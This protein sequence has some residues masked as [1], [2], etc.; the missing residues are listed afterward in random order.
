[1]LDLITKKRDGGALSAD[2]IRF[3]VGA[4][5][6]GSVPD[7]Q[8]SAWLMAVLLRGMTRAE[9]VALTSAMAASG[10]QL[11]LRGVKAPKADKHS[12]GGVGDGISL[13]LAPLVAAAGV[14]VPMMS[15]RGL[16]HTGGTL[17]KL[18]AIK[19]LRVRLGVD[20]VRRQMR[21][22]GVC[23]FGQSADFCPADRK[24]YALR[25]A[26]G[27]VQSRELIVGSILSKKL[28]E[29]LDA[30][31]LDIKCGS[32]AIFQEPA[33]AEELAK[34]LIRTAKGLGLPTVGLLTAMEQPLG[35]AIGNALEVRQAVEVLQGDFTSADYVEVLFGLG[36][37]MLALT[38]TARSAAAGEK[39]LKTL[40]REGKALEKFKQMIKAQGGDPRVADDP[41]R[42]LPKSKKSA[43]FAAGSAGYITRFD[44]LLAGRAGVALGAGRDRM[45]DRLDYGAGML[46]RRKVGDAVR[47]GE[48][49]ARLYSSSD[50]LLRGGLAML[51]RAVAIAP[52]RPRM[53]PV[54]RKIWR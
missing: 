50:R 44:A 42:F 14:A 49:I 11:T 35:R 45:E 18:E 32:G 41:E 24:L 25:D 1:M 47:K 51:E 7:Y 38:G 9:T 28:S 27:T 40:I 4:A 23:M 53:R 37:W 26:T 17:D 30:L 31:V 54:I 34:D 20:A 10:T 22:I 43:V 19:G 6:D 12:T 39:R 8:L 16:G 13:V 52:R 2:E 46:L 15:G 3:V 33:K 29:G 48:E 5:A 36:G 21:S